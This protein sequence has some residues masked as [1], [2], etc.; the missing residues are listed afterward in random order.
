MAEAPVQPK[1]LLVDDDGMLA[2]GVAELLQRHGYEVQVAREGRKAMDLLSRHRFALVISDIFMPEV[3]G[4]ELLGLLRRCTPSPAV[5]AMSGS[6]V[7]RV[8]CMLKMASVLGASRTLGKPFQPAH[9]IRLVQELIGPGV[10]RS[11]G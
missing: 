10:A 8:E 3:D 7:G 11:A 5:I 1:V 9:L 4:I 2:E 6:G